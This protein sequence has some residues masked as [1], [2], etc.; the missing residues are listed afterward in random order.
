MRS[1]LDP[2]KADRRDY[3]LLPS[4]KAGAIYGAT[5]T[6]PK[7]L[8]D[9]F[10]IFDG[11]K[12][13]NQLETDNRF[14]PPLDPLL[15]GCV[16][17]TAA[18]DAGIQDGAVYRPDVPYYNTPPYTNTSGRDMRVMLKALIDKEFLKTQEGTTGPKRT[19]FFNVYGAGKIDDFD[20]VRIAL[21]I[22]QNE[23]RGV[24]V[25]T[26][27]YPEFNH[28]G[29]SG[30]IFSPSY[31][32]TTASLHCHLIT[33]WKTIKGQIYLEDISWQGEDYAN[34]G[35]D[36]M[37]REIYNKLMTQPYT[38][39][40]TQTKLGANAPVPIGMTAVVDH[41]VYWLLQLFRNA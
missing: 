25:G 11:R 12:I 38:A 41:L 30:I 9:N 15:F 31:N 7:G 10:S 40:F 32:T 13:P 37:S 20:A 26:W 6:D 14:N 16:G 4:I 5:A 35:F 34:V 18:F 23:K 33:G 22:N 39:S 17:E 19:A 24:W 2:V 3:S 1:G 8:P 36:Y 27:W 28:V 21:W 29:R